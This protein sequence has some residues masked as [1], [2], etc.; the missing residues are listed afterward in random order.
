MSLLL[1]LAVLTVAGAKKKP[2]ET[3]VSQPA[4]ATRRQISIG[5]YNQKYF[6]AISNR[7]ALELVNNPV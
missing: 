1:L 2:L 4:S 3:E 5:L 7:S 6:K